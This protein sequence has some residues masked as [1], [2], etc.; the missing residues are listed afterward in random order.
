VL[1]LNAPGTGEEL[2]KERAATVIKK[3][4][5]LFTEDPRDNFLII[6]NYRRL[7]LGG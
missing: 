5:K 4:M 6:S 1:S 7:W 3:I 2:K